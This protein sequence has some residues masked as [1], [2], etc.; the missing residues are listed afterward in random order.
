MDI[1]NF[2]RS[3]RAKRGGYSTALVALV[4]ALVYLFNVIVLL[5]A[6]HFGWY[7]YTTEQYDLSIS[8]AAD[9]LF[10]DIDTSAGKVEILFCDVEENAKKSAQTDFIYRTANELAARYPDLIELSYV[11]LWLEPGRV[12]DYLEN[13][14]GDPITLLATDVIIDYQ[15]AHLVCPAE[16]FF[17]LDSENYVTAYNGEEVFVSNILWVTT[18]EHPTAYFTANHGESLP[19]PLYYALVRAGYR[20]DRID[21]ASV[22]AIPEDAGLVLISS[23]LYD[24]QRAADGA[25]FVAELTKLERYLDAGGKLFVSL[26]PNYLDRTPKLLAFLNEYGLAVSDGVLIDENGALPG[27]G[28]YSLIASFGDKESASR[29]LAAVG[30]DRRIVLSYTAPILTYEGERASAEPILLSPA[31]ATCKL[32]SGEYADGGSRP[33]LALSSMHGGEGK[34]LLVG[35]S[36]LAASDIMNGEGYGNKPLLYALLSELGAARVPL[37]IDAVAVDRSA[38]EDLSLGEVRLYTALTVAVIPLAL[39]SGGLILCRRRKGA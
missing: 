24:F 3:P 36:Y 22:E 21:L 33:I 11:N 1:K 25:A 6:N 10:A 32:R 4:I 37:G 14:A 34:I 31:G 13:E 2:L 5:F 23:P 8:E 26:E 29:L 7:F 17:T 12:S 18:P 9:A 30:E 38:I 16:S 15:G 35:S 27:S 28:G 20:V 19:T 39:L